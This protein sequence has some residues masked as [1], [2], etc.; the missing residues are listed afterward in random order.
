MKK[1]VIAIILVTA[2]IL[3]F[4]LPANAAAMSQLTAAKFLLRWAGYTQRDATNAGGWT[5]LVEQT[6]LVPDGYVFS[7]SAP[8]SGAMFEAMRQR[9]REL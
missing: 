3:A 1:R 6:K 4:A 7:P 2:M 9:A 8:C 5:A